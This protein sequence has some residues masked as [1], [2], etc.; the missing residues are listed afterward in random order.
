MIQPVGQY[1]VFKPFEGINISEGGI[2]IPDSM[3]KDSNKGKVVA[4]GNGS[5]K[6]PMK[7]KVG[8]IGFRVKDWGE[9]LIIEGEKHYLMTQQSIISL[10]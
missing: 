2:F 3:K 5:N 1:V 9:E 7:L 4:V 8:D 10:Q 6:I